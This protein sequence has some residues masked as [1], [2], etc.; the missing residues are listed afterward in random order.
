[1]C[2]DD[3]LERCDLARECCCLF[4]LLTQITYCASNGV[5][6]GGLLLTP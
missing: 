3:L 5:E 2:A 4:V 6:A 1:M